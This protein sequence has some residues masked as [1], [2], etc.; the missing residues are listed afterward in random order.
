[1]PAEEHMTTNQDHTRPAVL[2]RPLDADRATGLTASIEG[3]VAMA[4]TATSR[5]VQYQTIS[6]RKHR[7]ERKWSRREWP[8][9]LKREPWPLFGILMIQAVLSLRLVSS[10]TA[11]G[12]EALYLWSGH[13]EWAHW[14]HGTPVPNFP[15]YFSGA[16]VIYPP[17]GAVAD[18]IGGLA[19]AR[20]LSMIFMLVST[21]LLYATA[22]TLLLDR[23]AAFFSAAT[24]GLLGPTLSLA[25]ATYDAMA[26]MLMA[27]S[28]WL[29]ARASGRHP[30]PFLVLAGAVMALANATK[31]AS[32]LWDPVVVAV[33]VSA[34]WH[35]GPWI[36][37]LRGVRIAGYAGCLIMVA[38]F[39]FGGPAYE[40]GVLITTRARASASTPPVTVL[41]DAFDYIGPLIV[42]SLI[43]VIAS[44]RA[45]RR[46][47]FLCAS[48]AVACLLAPLN[49]A[50][51]HTITSLHKHVDF[52]AWFA[53][54][55]PAMSSVW[56]AGCSMSV[57]GALPSSWP[58][59]FLSRSSHLLSPA[60]CT[61]GH[62]Q[63]G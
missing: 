13:L 29:A 22:R 17:I 55:L 35:G 40:H 50:R 6:A 41:G 39:G 43:A 47:R 45:S 28:A 5:L 14:I 1:M 56:P 11:F 62:L 27:L 38:L 30:E 25:F 63:L 26:L 59:S 7:Q 15:A 37:V 3:T 48:V 34:S 61:A 33:A 24:F 42:L 51:I 54:S 8:R 16:P 10:N 36:R 20:I 46:I 9:F 19:A 4:P 21:M 60:T 23:T 18:G 44:V 32:A 53:A 2:R 31:Y 57:A 49:Q 58:P 52:G 12:D